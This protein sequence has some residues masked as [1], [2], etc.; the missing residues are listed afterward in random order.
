M[1]RDYVAALPA[2]R[3]PNL[4]ALADQF[5]LVDADTRFNLLLDIYIEGLARHAAAH[6]P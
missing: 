4:V 3:F 2:D 1:A 5:A 6:G